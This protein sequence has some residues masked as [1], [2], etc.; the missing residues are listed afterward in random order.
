MTHLVPVTHPCDLDIAHVRLFIVI[1]CCLLDLMMMGEGTG[2]ALMDLIV[3]RGTYVSL[4]LGLVANLDIGEMILII[5][6]DCAHDTVLGDALLDT[7]LISTDQLVLCSIMLVM[8]IQRV[9]SNLY[10]SAIYSD[11]R[12]V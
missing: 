3:S 8:F 4:L 7:A 6:V 2:A 5:T 10:L 12:P 1:M 9:A 11:L